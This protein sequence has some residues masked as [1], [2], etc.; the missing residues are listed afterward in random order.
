MEEKNPTIERLADQIDWYDIASKKSKTL[1][2]ALKFTSITA[3]AFVPLTAGIGSIQLLTGCLGVIIVLLEGIQHLNQYHQNWISYRTT[4]ESLK[5]EK[6]LFL[7]GAGPYPSVNDPQ[8][9]LAERIEY[10]V[11]GEH[12]K[13]ISEQEKSEKIPEKSK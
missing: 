1:Y 4:C 8:V 12:S 9:L 2:K 3:A 13:W 5:H 7:A 6:Y 11:S 10:L